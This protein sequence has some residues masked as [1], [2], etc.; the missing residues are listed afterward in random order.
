MS[1]IQLLLAAAFLALQGLPC[2]AQGKGKLVFITPEDMAIQKKTMNDLNQLNFDQKLEIK[3]LNKQLDELN[4]EQ[5][6]MEKMIQKLSEYLGK[7]S[8]P[9]LRMWTARNG[10]K[11]LA[12]A[13]KKDA[14]EVTLV[15]RD[16]AE[17]KI[18]RSILSDQDNAHLDLLEEIDSALLKIMQDAA[19]RTGT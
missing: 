15:S 9:G 17:K 18:R 11:M 19:A 14:V 8:E 12:A 3:K 7:L 10:T 4:A 5:Q 2:S 1:R 13:D 6:R 16:G